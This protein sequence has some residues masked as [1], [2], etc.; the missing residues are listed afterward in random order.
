MNIN[1]KQIILAGDSAGGNLATA[2]TAMAI[3][4]GVQKP[5][6]LIL[7]YPA[8]SLAKKIVVPSLFYSFTDPI[9]NLN[10]LNLCFQSYLQK[11]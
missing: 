5:D 4:N 8:L 7:P 3:K 10:F 9:L 1:P 2:V 11:G 6:L